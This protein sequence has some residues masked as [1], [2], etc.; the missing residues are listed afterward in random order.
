PRPE[1]FLDGLV[2]RTE[3]DCFAITDPIGGK[4]LLLHTG[5]GEHW[6]ELPREQLPAALPQ[7]GAFAASNSS[8]TLCGDSDLFFGTGG[9]AARVF[10]SPDNGK[11]WSV[12]ETPILSGNAS[13]GIFSLHCSGN[14][15]IAVGGDYRK[16]SD[17]VRVAAYST[18]RGATWKL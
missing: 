6:T 16:T 4:F 18:D 10:H 2:C 17:E 12:A 7:E 11:T 5:D 9:P 14:V 8:L 13:S 15:V 1:F 3:K